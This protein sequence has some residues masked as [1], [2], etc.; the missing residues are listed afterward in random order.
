MHLLYVLRVYGTLGSLWLRRLGTYTSWRSH[1]ELYAIVRKED[2]LELRGLDHS[3]LPVPA[4]ARPMDPEEAEFLSELFIFPCVIC[5]HSEDHIHDEKWKLRE[6]VESQSSGCA[7]GVTESVIQ[8]PGLRALSMPT[9]F[10]AGFRR[11]HWQFT[12]AVSL[13]LRSDY[14]PT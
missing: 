4:F 1:V 6:T 5:R 2:I 13:N 11:L 12:S 9:I 3:H 8:S 7:G 14:L 10:H